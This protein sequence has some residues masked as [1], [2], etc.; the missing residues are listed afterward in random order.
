MSEKW[1]YHVSGALLMARCGHRWYLENVEGRRSPTRTFLAAGTGVDRSVGQDLGT[2]IATGELL[3]IEQCIDIARDETV[4][5]LDEGFELTPDERPIGPKAARGAAIDKA[6]RLARL[7][8]L[9]V[10]PA[11]HPSHV[12]RRFTIDVQGYDFQL[13]GEMDIRE[14]S[15][16][17]V[18]I[19]DTKTRRGRAPSSDEAQVSTQLTMYSLGEWVETKGRIPD[20]VA[21]DFL[22]D[23][24]A[25]PGRGAGR[26]AWEAAERSL[27]EMPSGVPMSQVAKREFADFRPLLDRFQMLDEARQKGVFYPADPSVPGAW[28]CSETHC[29]HW[30][31]CRYMRRPVSTGGGLVQISSVEGTSL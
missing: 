2:K 4:A 18:I 30:A 3:E 6:A 27:G 12:A 16:G 11:I 13:V 25:K 19:R 28:W 31:D 7:H 14:E 23:Y 1:Q 17:L 22:I 5:R 9:L 15:R 20:L 24:K 26:D 21:L 8:R 29:P 10:A